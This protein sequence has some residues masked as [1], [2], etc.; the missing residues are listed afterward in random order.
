MDRH[1]ELATAG[2]RRQRKP[3]GKGPTAH[4]KGEEGGGLEHAEA[5]QHDPGPEGPRNGSA[6]GPV[7]PVPESRRR[8]RPAVDEADG[9]RARQERSLDAFLR[10][11]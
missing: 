7:R 8:D 11:V 9:D 3:D 6:Q 10:K 5:T 1:P 2:S 4:S